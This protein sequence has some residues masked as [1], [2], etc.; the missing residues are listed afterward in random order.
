MWTTLDG[1][2][3]KLLLVLQEASS[4]WASS[5][6]DAT[7]AA[8]SLRAPLVSVCRF[9]LFFPRLS[10]FPLPACRHGFSLLL[11][12]PPFPV[13]SVRCHI[14]FSQEFEH[15]LIISDSC[16][17][18]VCVCES[19]CVCACVCACMRVSWQRRPHRRAVTSISV[20]PA[21]RTHI[22][23]MCVHARAKLKHLPVVFVS[24]AATWD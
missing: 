11:Q 8:E 24:G 19:K 1:S 18:R 22:L 14:E 17:S 13:P 23:C 7:S 3:V 12:F 6:G 20:P 9:S 2:R 4:N 21:W 15:E 16:C 5:P 10:V